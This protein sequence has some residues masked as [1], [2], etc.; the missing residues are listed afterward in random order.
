MTAGLTAASNI[1]PEAVSTSRTPRP[2]W[3]PGR[4]QSGQR[5][6]YRVPRVVKNASYRKSARTPQTT[7]RPC[8]TGTPLPGHAVQ[9]PVPGQAVQ[10]DRYQVRQ[11]SGTG[12]RTKYP[13]PV[14]VPR[15]QYPVPTTQHPYPVPTT[16]V[17]TTAPRSCPSPQCPTPGLAKLA[18]PLTKRA[19][20][21]HCRDTTGNTGFG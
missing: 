13:V 21:N 5:V 1:N 14:P 4:V 20:E 3:Q 19:R 12:T 6:G 18:K 11:Y 16:R 15:T 7:A 2:L 9:G 17:P 8:S 10:W